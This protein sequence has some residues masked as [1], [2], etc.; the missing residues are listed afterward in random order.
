MKPVASFALVAMLACANPAA[1]Q[2]PACPAYE[3]WRGADDATT[4]GF[5][6]ALGFS[7]Q[8]KGASINDPAPIRISVE[9]ARDMG[10][11]KFR[12]A[13][14]RVYFAQGIATREVT[15]FEM[16]CRAD[17]LAT[18]AA[19]AKPKLC[20]AILTPAQNGSTQTGLAPKGDAHA[21]L[22]R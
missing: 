7:T 12:S 11:G 5:A 10:E 16:T 14:K 1:A 8:P 3:L 15:L 21:D 13:L 9:P 20:A 22:P 2:A 17:D 19:I 18:C 4:I 6:D